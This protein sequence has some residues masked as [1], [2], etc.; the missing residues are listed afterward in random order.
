MSVA[1]S[2]KATK[3]GKIARPRHPIR[4]RV[5]KVISDGH[6]GGAEN[7]AE[8]VEGNFGVEGNGDGETLRISDRRAQE[9]RQAQQFQDR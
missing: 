4:S 3:I 1:F 5:P 2:C 9:E 7:A 6:G 8:G